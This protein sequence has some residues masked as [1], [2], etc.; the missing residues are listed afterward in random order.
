MGLISRIIDFFRNLFGSTT[1]S[2]E[3]KTAVGQTTCPRDEN[4]WKCVVFKNKIFVDAETN[5]TH[6]LDK[7]VVTRNG[8]YC[9]EDKDW[10]GRIQ[11]DYSGDVWYQYRNGNVIEHRNP[12]KQNDVHRMVLEEIIGY[13]TECVIPVVVMHKN[14]SPIPDCDLII[15]EIDLNKF[16]DSHKSFEP[17]LSDSEFDNLCNVI[18]NNISNVSEYQHIRNTKTY[19]KNSSMYR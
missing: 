4:K 15:N 11:G 6:E 2:S 1:T 10:F 16:I 8:V 5:H 12:I 7:I 18:T 19:S 14:N 17:P 3:N 9:I 13:D